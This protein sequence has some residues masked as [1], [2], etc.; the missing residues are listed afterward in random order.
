MS[1]SRAL[2]LG[3]KRSTCAGVSGNAC[4]GGAVSG[5]LSEFP[6]TSASARGKRV[7][8]GNRRVARRRDGRDSRARTSA[9]GTH[10]A[11]S[12]TGRRRAVLVADAAKQVSVHGLRE[13]DPIHVTEASSRARVRE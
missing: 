3:M 4:R 11:L 2:R 6:E 1:R 8:H 7:G 13:V 10:R 12:F 9:R 5:D